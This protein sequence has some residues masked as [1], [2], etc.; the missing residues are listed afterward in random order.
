MLLISGGVFLLE[1]GLQLRSN[2]IKLSKLNR[3]QFNILVGN[4]PNPWVKTNWI[5][6]LCG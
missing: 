1:L 6:D 5:C 3:F 2:Q 4:N